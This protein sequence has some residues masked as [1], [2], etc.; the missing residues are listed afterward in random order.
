MAKYI[1]SKSEPLVPVIRPKVG[2]PYHVNWGRSHGVVGICIAVDETN[3][4]VTLR[5]PSTGKVFKNAVS[6]SDLRH[7]RKNQV[8]NQH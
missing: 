4:T 6:W 3:K 8:E 1:F 7:T 2:T 5:T